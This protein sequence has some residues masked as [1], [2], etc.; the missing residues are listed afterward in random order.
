MKRTVTIGLLG[1]I[2]AIAVGFISINAISATPFFIA[3][4]Q[5]S[6][7]DSAFMMM[8]HVEYTVRD[9]TGQI[10]QYVQGPNRIVETGTDCTAQLI[11]DSSGTSA[12]TPNGDGFNFI[13]IGNGSGTV[14]G[15][16]VELDFDAGTNVGEMNRTS[17]TVTLDTAGTNTVATIETTNPFS[18]RLLSTTGTTV[19]QSGLFDNVGTATPDNMFSMRDALGV[20]GGNA[21]TLE[22]TWKVT[23]ANGP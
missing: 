12:C 20:S 15:T 10:K 13:A 1:A 14:D 19:E 16:E 8:G 23:L 18:F 2:L 5:V 22:V 3:A 6:T 7:N 21:D 11:F 17:A 4:N 9:A